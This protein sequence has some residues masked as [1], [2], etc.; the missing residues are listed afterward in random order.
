MTNK[1]NTVLY[2]GVTSDLKKRV[3]E[4]KEKLAE[5]FTSKYN[6]KKL[7]YYEVCDDSYQAITREKQI[8]SG[9]RKRK[10]E[11]IHTLNSDWRD[12]YDEI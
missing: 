11:L 5:G 2:V 9:T 4:H 6:L 3:Y 10:I 7:I 12:I 8:K 1:Y